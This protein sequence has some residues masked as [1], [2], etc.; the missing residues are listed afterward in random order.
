VRDEVFERHRAHDGVALSGANSVV[1]HV[2]DD[3]A[4]PVAHDSLDEVGTHAPE[5]DHP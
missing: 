1:V 4:V 3:G 5:P 2:K